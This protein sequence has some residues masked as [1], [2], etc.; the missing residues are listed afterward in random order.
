VTHPD[1]IALAQEFVAR[2]A[3]GEFLQSTTWFNGATNCP[4][5]EPG[6]DALRIVQGFR[7]AFDT[8]VGDTIR[9]RVTYR[10]LGTLAGGNHIQPDS[11]TEVRVLKLTKGPVGWR[12]ESPALD[13]H[14]TLDVVVTL[15]WLPDSLRRRLLAIA[16]SRG[17]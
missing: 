17:A 15:R 14:L 1:P 3:R 4:G 10:V 2:D 5:H 8:V 11:G 12:I 16:K 7:I 6:P 13:Q 9:A